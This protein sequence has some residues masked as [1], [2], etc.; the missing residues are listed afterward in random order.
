MIWSGLFPS[1]QNLP[2]NFRMGW[3]LWL[4]QMKMTRGI[5][6]PLKLATRGIFCLQEMMDS[7]MLDMA[8]VQATEKKGTPCILIKKVEPLPS[9]RQQHSPCIQHFLVTPCPSFSK[10]HILLNINSPV[11]D[12]LS[13][14]SFSLFLSLTLSP[15]QKS[16]ASKMSERFVGHEILLGMVSNA[17]H[18]VR[19]HLFILPE[20]R[21]LAQH[22]IMYISLFFPLPLIR[23]FRKARMI[24]TGGSRSWRPA[25]RRRTRKP[26]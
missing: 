26:W 22:G 16:E 10:V 9:P 1:R 19:T 12:L 17:A 2:K 20:H 5:F 14:H 18:R 4:L 11:W 8:S 25:V 21:L 24:C 15:W 23:K 3:S 13:E 7:M 6:F